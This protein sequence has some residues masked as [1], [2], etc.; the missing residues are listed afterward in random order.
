M[1]CKSSH[2]DCTAKARQQIEAR[3]AAGAA[4][5]KPPS[6]RTKADILALIA[7]YDAG[8]AT[9][10][11]QKQNAL[12]QLDNMPLEMTRGEQNNLLERSALLAEIEAEV[13]PALHNYRDPSRAGSHLLNWLRCSN[14]LRG[15]HI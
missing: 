8:L 2:C 1:H 10:Q 13:R 15:R 12:S 6:Q 3:M 7:G 5:S 11:A 9:L 4:L 14:I